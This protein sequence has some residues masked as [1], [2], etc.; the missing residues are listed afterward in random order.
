MLRFN[1]VAYK[2][3]SKDLQFQ[4]ILC[5]GSTFIFFHKKIPPKIFQYILCYG[6]TRLSESGEFE[7]TEF[8][9]ILCYGSTQSVA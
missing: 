1:V 2:P 8:Q 6:S 4:Y 5:Y 7:W 3:Y 9:Y